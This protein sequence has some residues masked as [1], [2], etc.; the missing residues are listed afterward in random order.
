MNVL[1]GGFAPSQSKAVLLMRISWS[2]KPLASRGNAKGIPGARVFQSCRRKSSLKVKRLPQ[3][4]RR[5]GAPQLPSYSTT[6]HAAILPKACQRC[7]W[8]M[9]VGSNSSAAQPSTIRPL[10]LPVNVAYWRASITGC[11]PT[12]HATSRKIPP[13]SSSNPAMMPIKGETRNWATLP[14]SIWRSR[15]AGVSGRGALG[16]RGPEA[17][18]RLGTA[19][20]L[21]TAARP[22]QADALGA[23]VSGRQGQWAL[24]RAAVARPAGLPC[25]E[26]RP[27]WAHASLRTVDDLSSR[28]WLLSPDEVIP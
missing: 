5:I 26:R 12:N 17:A 1:C 19:A 23:S 28:A 27:R 11:G 4:A 18:A 2:M 8:P 6:A 14:R 13:K 16:S 25:G 15:V 20:S 9:S 22:G 7:F 24:L 3:N 10:T 21:A